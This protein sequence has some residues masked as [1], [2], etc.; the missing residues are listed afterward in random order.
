MVRDI[1]NAANGVHHEY[2][3]RLEWDKNSAEE[4]LTG[5]TYAIACFL[6]SALNTGVE[7]EHVRFT[8]RLREDIRN[9][10]EALVSD[11]IYELLKG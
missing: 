9:D 5:G 8:L 7:E 2:K 3:A 1:A 6:A 11:L 4:Y 10:R